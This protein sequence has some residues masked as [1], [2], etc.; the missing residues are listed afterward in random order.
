[1]LVAGAT[2][3]G[4]MMLGGILMRWGAGRLRSNALVGWDDR[5]L[6]G[7][8]LV[9]LGLAILVAEAVAWGISF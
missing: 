4:A 5:V 7:A 3:L 2:G 1:M 8:A 6:A 9:A